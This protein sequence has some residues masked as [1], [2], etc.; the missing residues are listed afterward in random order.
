MIP[1]GAATTTP[2]NSM[3]IPFH[4]RAKE[5]AT[6]RDIHVQGRNAL[7]LGPDGVGKTSLIV[8][9]AGP[10]DLLVCHHSETPII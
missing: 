3:G 6:L 4:G 2:N 7:V 1:A 8:H 10:L 5:I 9:L